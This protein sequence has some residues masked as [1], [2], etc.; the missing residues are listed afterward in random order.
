MAT[1]IATGLNQNSPGTL[2]GIQNQ[3]YFVNGYDP[4]KVWDGI[5][6][7]TSDAGITGPA[8]AIGNPSSTAG[9]SCTIGT[10]GI[11][12]RYMNSRMGYV[13]NPSP[14]T[15]Y[16]VAGGA[17]QLTY[18]IAGGGPIFTSAD[19]K[20]DTILIEM[21]ALLSGDYWQVAKVANVA[22]S[23]SISISDSLLTQ[24]L[25]SDANYGSA[26]KNEVFTH[27]PPPY[28]TITLAY[29]GR[30]WIFGNTPFTLTA[31]FTNASANVTAMS[32][33]FSQAWVGQVIKR[34]TDTSA[35]VIA[36][37][38][39]GANSMVL[40]AV[41][42][43]TGGTGAS[44]VYSTTPNR[45]YY[46]RP[47]APEE[48]F[49][50]TWAR[51]FLQDRDDIITSVIGRRDAMYI[52]GLFSAERLQY[53][54]DPSAT[55]STRSPIQGN[56]GCFNQRCL[57]GVEGH[58]YSFD[59]QGI[60][61]VS[62]VPE[63]LSAPIDDYLRANVDYSKYAQ[64]HASFDPVERVLLF[65]FVRQGDT[66]PKYA[67][68]MEVD[69]GRWFFD[70]WFQS[71]T[72]SAIVPTSDGQVRM[73]LCDG[74]G[75]SWFFGVDGS[76][77][78]VPPGSPTVI[79]CT[80]S[81]NSLVIVSE[82]LPGSN[83]LLGVTLYRPSTGES[84]VCST[85]TTTQIALATNFSTVTTIGETLYL[86]PIQLEYQTKWW[87][88]PSQG[89]KKQPAYLN[90]SMYPGSSTGTLRVY[91]YSDFATA[92]T[93]PTSFPTDN[94][95]KGVSVPSNVS[96]I[97]VNLDGGGTSHDGFVSVPLGSSFQR[98]VKAR[99]TSIRPDGDLRIS[100]IEFSFTNKQQLAAG[101]GE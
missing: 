55:T 74:N 1:N 78:G 7:T 59:R 77:D 69:T 6:A 91:V 37:G 22:G 99:I 8:A 48:Y 62:D 101:I 3:I 31:T 81:S 87:T 40:Q 36:S 2:T 20:V 61:S 72:A 53:D 95:P 82:T 67:A 63:H 56:R 26:E 14:A 54:A 42:G 11:R 94:F 18:T 58:L 27:S 76:F 98:A 45:G 79:T 19:A 86:G 90:I 9:G 47:Y 33:N 88:G 39:T 51:D 34:G 43:G 21:T 66:Q 10:H 100:K 12:Y 85:N 25:N 83:L 13:S 52:F 73:L 96:Y 35:Y 38:T 93:T 89:G 84:V 64:F 65:Y 50:A 44:T 57:V 97:E 41:Y 16:A 4:C 15:L 5:S 49:P 71:M 24:N 68:C 92:P 29:K 70:S 30:A 23:Y 46:S 60:W 80:N 32:V 28:G 17:Q 75:Y